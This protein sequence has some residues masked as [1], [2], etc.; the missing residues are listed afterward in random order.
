MGPY[1]FES[2]KENITIIAD[3]QSFSL[4]YQVIPEVKIFFTSTAILIR[5][6]Y[7]IHKQL[8]FIRYV[9]AICIH[10]YVQVWF[11]IEIFMFQIWLQ[12]ARV[13]DTGICHQSDISQEFMAGG[14]GLSRPV[15][16]IC[17]VCACLDFL[18]LFLLKKITFSIFSVPNTYTWN[19]LLT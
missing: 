1:K 2:I 7:N 11:D 9:T 14:S 8:M 13:P 12:L 17:Q 16:S 19:S 15:S 18:A 5:P 3:L 10:Q 6:V 4:I